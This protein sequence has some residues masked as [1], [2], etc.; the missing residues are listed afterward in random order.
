MEPRWGTNQ[1]HHDVQRDGNGQNRARFAQKPF[2]PVVGSVTSA[3]GIRC[4]PRTNV[5]AER[6]D[7]FSGDV[8]RRRAQGWRL[9]VSA[10]DRL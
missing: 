1:C 10:Q 7:R 5:V 9:L 4:R 2:R 8:L 3:R 6:S